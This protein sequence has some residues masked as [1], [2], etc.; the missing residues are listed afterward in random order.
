MAMT[1][2]TTFMRMTVAMFLAASDAKLPASS[3]ST[4][5]TWLAA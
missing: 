5:G 2:M 4:L 3:F 1:V